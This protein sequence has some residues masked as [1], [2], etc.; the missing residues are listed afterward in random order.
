MASCNT[1]KIRQASELN[2][3]EYQ[4]L[5]YTC[6]TISSRLDAMASLFNGPMDSV[7]MMGNPPKGKVIQVDWKYVKA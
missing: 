3:P 1:C 6:R 7:S 2:E 5:C 4:G